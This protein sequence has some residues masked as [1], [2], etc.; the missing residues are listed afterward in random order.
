MILS[1]A[2]NRLFCTSYTAAFQRATSDP[3]GYWQEQAKL[4]KWHTFPKTMLKIDDLH[5]YQWF[6]DGKINIS[7]Q[8]LDVH[9]ADRPDQVI[10]WH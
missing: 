6:P 1:R 4:V 8:C 2:I 7:E 5:F 10:F 9:L 3:L